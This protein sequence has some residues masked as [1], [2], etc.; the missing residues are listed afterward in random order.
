MNHWPLGE[1][2]SEHNGV[3]MR[4][5]LKSESDVYDETSMVERLLSMVELLAA[6][7][8]ALSALMRRLSLGIVTRPPGVVADMK[9]S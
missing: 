3:T 6:A 5:L 2:A 1:T 7:A 4:L 9:P 8:A